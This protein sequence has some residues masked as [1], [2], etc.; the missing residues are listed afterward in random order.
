MRP[1]REIK[2]FEETVVQIDRVTHVVAGGR[3]FR[4]RATVVIGDKK[5]KV[6]VGVARGK[7]VQQ[8]IA[9]AVYKAKK[10]IIEVPFKDTTVPYEVNMSFGGA[11][12]MLKPAGRGTG[13]MAGGP[14]RAVLEAAGI[15]DV[16]SKMFGSS[17]RVN[18]VYATYEALKKLKK[19]SEDNEA[20]RQKSAVR[21]PKKP[22]AKKPAV[23]KESKK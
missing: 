11:K 3:R 4:F 18:N 9:K 10:S 7:D 12:I 19:V 1:P 17:S 15:K 13:V 6:G 21:A 8:A 22:A 14:V 2:E 5:G 23:K 16:L 20:R